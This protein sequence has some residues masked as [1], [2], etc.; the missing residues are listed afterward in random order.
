[1]VALWGFRGPCPEL[2]YTEKSFSFLALFTILTMN[3]CVRV[4][5]AQTG[6]LLVLPIKRTDK[7]SICDMDIYYL[8][9]VVINESVTIVVTV[10]MPG[11]QE[12]DASRLGA[13]K[14]S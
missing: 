3:A 2:S 13:L 7:V 14:F 10:E 4:L 8:L 11:K 12:H 6:H 9:R 1:M 5:L